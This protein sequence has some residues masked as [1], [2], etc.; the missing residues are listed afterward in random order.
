MKGT[1]GSNNR[2]DRM[3]IRSQNNAWQVQ[4][5]EIIGKEPIY[6]ETGEVVN[7]SDHFGLLA[8]LHFQ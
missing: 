3:L 4:S 6:I 1:I 7:I 5:I 2:F 8:Q